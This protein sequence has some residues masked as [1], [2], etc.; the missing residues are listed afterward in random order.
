MGPLFENRYHSTWRQMGEFNQK[1]RTGPRLHTMV[2][3]FLCLAFAVLACAQK[4]IL[5]RMSPFLIGVGVSF[6]LIPTIP[7]RIAKTAIRRY[8]RQHDGVQPET[9][10]TFGDKIEVFEGMAHFTIEYRKIVQVRRFRHS[11]ALM[12]SRRTAVLLRE[13]G[14]SQ[15]TFD[16]F[17]DFLRQKLPQI[18]IPE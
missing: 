6:L 12:T 8:T 18:Q 1:C 17:K 5:E 10:I 9:V 14:F 4:G 16:D 11:Y 3:S 15:G 13:D 2:I 7:Y